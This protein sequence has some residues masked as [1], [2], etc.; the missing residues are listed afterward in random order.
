MVAA[1]RNTWPWLADPYGFLRREALREGRFTFQRDL[2]V[3]G[4]TLLTGDPSVVSEIVNHPDLDAGRG[5]TGLRAILGDD[6]LIMLDGAA[7]T[8]RRVL[9]APAF[10]GAVLDRYGAMLVEVTREHARGLPDTFSGHGL[11]HDISLHAIARVVFGDDPAVVAEARARIARF[12]RSTASPLMLFLRPLQVDLGPASPWG[13]ALR[14][15]E[16]LRALCRERVGASAGLLSDLAAQAPG[17]APE[18]LV[19][20]VLAL[21]LFGHDTGAAQM[22]WALCHLH[23]HGHAQR[24]G[25]DP[26]WLDACLRESMRMCPVVVHLTRVANRPVQ[27]GG[28]EVQTD[29]RVCPSAWLAHHNPAL[30]PD[31]ERFDPARFVDGPVPAHAWFPFGLGRRVCVGMPFVMRQMQHVIGTL[32]REGRWRLASGYTPAPRRQM[33]LVVPSGGC[34]LQRAT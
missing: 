21:L 27:I 24:A 32:L 28:F 10:R 3:L 4:R 25:E 34:P 30:W 29:G 11:V 9:V 15:R 31:P 14:H 23:Q 22:A 16:A 20:E 17:L 5:V 2:P 13:R 7:H 18:V 33:V 8:A 26:A 6:S 12:L 1:L 19:T